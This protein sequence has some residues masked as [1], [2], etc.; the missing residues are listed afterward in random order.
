MH[1]L[2][3]GRPW[4]WHW[5]L[6]DELVDDRL[7]LDADGDGEEAFRPPAA[8]V[9]LTFM[10]ATHRLH[11]QVGLVLHD[12]P[13]Q[14]LAAWRST[15]TLKSFQ[16]EELSATLHLSIFFK[17]NIATK[18]P[19]LTSQMSGSSAGPAR[20]SLVVAGGLISAAALTRFGCNCN[21]DTRLC[22]NK[23]CRNELNFQ[24]SETTPAEEHA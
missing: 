14:R 11:L 5:Y 12:A 20:S 23:L 15:F 17:D 6:G 18:R 13:R 22:A 10:V 8:A 3:N 16:H 4:Q 21:T 1:K 7:L 19:S 9:L 2:N 24:D